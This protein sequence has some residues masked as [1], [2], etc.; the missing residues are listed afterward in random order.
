MVE[1]N[2]NQYVDRIFRND[3]SLDIDRFL[4]LMKEEGFETITEIILMI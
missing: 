1:K 4:E 2:I 3:I